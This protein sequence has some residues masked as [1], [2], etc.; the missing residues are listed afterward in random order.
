MAIRPRQFQEGIVLKE[1]TTALDTEG[2]LA[3]KDNKVKAYIEGNEKEVIT[4]DQTQTLENKTIDGTAA[5]GNNTVTADSDNISYDPAASG[6]SATDV[7]TAIDELKTGLDNQNEASEIDYDN[8]TSGLTATNVQDAVDE[9]DGRIDTIEGATYVNSFNGRTGAVITASSDYDAVQVDYDNST[10]GLTATDTQAAIDEVE[11]RVDTAETSISTN[12]TD[13]GTNN[14]LITDHI[15]DGVGAHA[16]SAISNIPAGNLAATEVQGALNELQ[17]DVDTR[18]LDSDLTD[19]INDA[20]G[21]HA[22]SAISSIASGNLAATDVQGAL[23]ELQTDID[24]R[25]LDA[26]LT[27]HTGASSGVHGVTGNVVGDTDTQTLTN[28]TLTGASIETPTRLDTKQDTKANLD[29]YVLTATNGQ[30]CFA[31]DTKT[32]YQVIDNSLVELAA[33]SSSVVA[34]GARSNNGQSVADGGV[35]I[36]E[37][38]EYDTDSAYNPATGVFTVPVGQGGFYRAS[39]SMRR[40]VGGV[41]QFLTRIVIQKNGVN[42]ARFYAGT[43]GVDQVASGSCVIELAAGDTVRVIQDIGGFINVGT[44]SED[45]TFFIE[46]I[47]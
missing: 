43:T 23:D 4:N 6:L 41:S 25:A 10:S 9:V 30:F 29:V 13:I 22:A 35:V 36:Y 33:A 38:E 46:K 27:A 3:N 40:A 28:K 47:N 37:D 21:A 18:A 14:T 26:D 20:V 17:T 16:A 39:A 1:K 8:S 31:T 44:G 2:Q 15:A 32:M 11:G 24:T 7:K 45:N 5:T 12:T 34:A 42:Y 19:H